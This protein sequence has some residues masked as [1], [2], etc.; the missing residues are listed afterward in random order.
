[1]APEIDP[2]RLEAILN[3]SPHLS[4]L[5]TK[6]ASGDVRAYFT[7]PA[8]ERVERALDD[9]A[10]AKLADQRAIMKALRIAKQQV[11]LAVALD[12]RM[13]YADLDLTVERLSLFADKALEC[14]VEA[15]LQIESNNGRGHFGSGSEASAANS[16]YTVFAMGKLGAR[17][18]N[19]SSDIDLIVLFDPQKLNARLSDRVDAPTFAVRVTRRLVNL[20]QDR[21]EDG[22]VFRTDL[23]LRP[24]PASTPLA[25]AFDGAV[26]YYESQGRTWERAAMI[27]ARCVAGD[28]AVGADFLDA[29]HP[30]VWRRYLDYAAI[31]SIRAVKRQINAHKGF[32][33]ITVPGHDVKLGRGGIREVEFFAQTQQ[34]IAGGRVEALR[35]PQTKLALAAL[36]DEGWI[37]SSERDALT[38]A[39]NR[40]RHVE[41][42]IQMVRDEQAHCLPADPDG[43]EPIATLMGEGPEAF[44][45]KTLHA[46]QT[47]HQTFL[48]LFPQNDPGGD[49]D[50]FESELSPRL[51]AHLTALGYAEPR[52]VHRL[53]HSLMRGGM[54]ATATGLARD[55]LR[56]IAPHLI[57]VFGRSDNPQAALLAFDRF[58]RAMSAGMQFFS[59]L[60][61]NP[62]VIELLARI[63]GTAPRLADVIARR[64]GLIDAVLDPRFFGSLP[65]RERIHADLQRAVE[66]ADGYEAK[67]NACRV[68][69]Q[70]HH[71][72]IGVRL[73]SQTL[74]AKEAARAY[75]DLA[76]EVVLTL[77]DLAW[78]DVEIAHGSF[79]DATLTVLAMGKLGSRELTASSDLDMLLIYDVAPEL[80]ESDGRKP[81]APSHYFTRVTQRLIAALSAP[82]AEGMLY[83]L[84]MRLRPSG[85]AGPLATSLTAFERYQKNAARTWEHMA[86]TRARPLGRSQPPIE[87]LN[88]VI[89]DVLTTSRQPQPTAQDVVSM[90]ALIEQEKSSAGAF[91]LKLSPGAL[92]DVEFVAQGMQLM[93]AARNPH[94]LKTSTSDALRALTDEGII[95]QDDGQAL[96]SAHRLYSSLSQILRLCVA[97]NFD[98]G[99]AAPSLR[100]LIGE[101]CDLPSLHLVAAHLEQTQAETRERFTR[102]FVA[103]GHPPRVHPSGATHSKE[104]ENVYPQV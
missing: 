35:V 27:K 85:G 39:Y 16:G 58:L 1:M 30:F 15:A 95:S 80:P 19:Y 13:A 25:I 64:P 43:R 7:I 50:L 33:A 4:H 87:A 44:E 48:D 46:L 82:T 57:S 2:N 22:Y 34:L 51:E 6:Q 60:A 67:L 101:A 79:P 37:T 104:N 54:N 10:S 73:L 40:L 5:W 100:Q 66:K 86:L 55:R 97:G 59:M 18:L 68:V 42:C 70:E 62:K 75:T 92:L 81:L 74:T 52:D 23:R 102:L 56:E 47:V 24:D 29:I 61:S 71:F 65:S 91:D 83:E 96:L 93:H 98:P 8:G 12:D 103:A 36:A 17:E 99:Q 41:H 14:A 53:M 88:K 21:T 94:L 69:G 9:L 26:N 11:S 28:P 20:L 72:L 32:G 77:L 38:G 49:V 31:D 89:N 45:R 90:R 3:A 76:D 63:M 78:A 84:D